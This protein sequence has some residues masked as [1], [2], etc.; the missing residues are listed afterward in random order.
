MASVPT[1]S[2]FTI[3]KLTLGIRLEIMLDNIYLV[4]EVDI[5]QSSTQTIC[6]FLVA[7]MTTL[8]SLMIYGLTVLLH[9]SGNKLLLKD[10]EALLLAVVTLLISL[11]T[12]WSSSEELETLFVN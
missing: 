6:L 10:R 1:V 9:L 5:L 8:K 3:S 12:T 11:E 4:L 2:L 7:R